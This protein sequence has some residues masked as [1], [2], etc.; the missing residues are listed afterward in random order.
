MTYPPYVLITPA[1]NE[2]AC[3][4]QTIG[5]V[6]GQTV[7]PQAWVIVSDG[8]VDRTEAIV[9]K[10]ARKYS[11]VQLVC[12]GKKGHK[13]FGSK[14]HAF[15]A[16][17]RQVADIPAEFL[18]NLDADVTFEPDY[19]EQILRR[20]HNTPRLGIGGGIIWERV[21]TRFIPQH[22]SLTSVA[23]AVQFFRRSCYE[24]FGGY[25]PI[26]GG[27]IDAAA[28]IMA[29]MHGWTVQTFPDLP[30]C[31]HRRVST[32][33]ATILG[34]RFHQG[35]TNYLLGYHPLFQILS[36]A[37]RVVERPYLIGSALNLLGYASSAIRRLERPMQEDVVRF[38]RSEQAAR[39]TP[40][41]WFRTRI[42]RSA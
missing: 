13:D 32:G 39:I 8:S 40:S 31:H 12:T 15:R 6:L 17:Y 16:G 19:F 41:G 25:I 2:E 5:S 27:G 3:I 26:K 28:E 20:F 1:K 34:S 24:S 7:L 42:T 22:T 10:Y 18:G 35:V 21:G 36:C 30:V 23:G 4:E 14:V 38:L 37:Y 9:E 29:R 11:F 33:R